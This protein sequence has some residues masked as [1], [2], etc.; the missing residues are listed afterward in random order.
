MPQRA[1]VTGAAGFIGSHLVDRLLG[2]RW[3]VTGVDNF[4]PF[5]PREVKEA[6]IRD[7]R[8]HAGYRMVEIDIRDRA[9]LGTSG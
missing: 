3:T 5:Y 2:E 4:D 7:H 6:H 8:R 9:A 1:L